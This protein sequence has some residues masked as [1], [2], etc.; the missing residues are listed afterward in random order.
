MLL[1]CSPPSEL[2]MG[3]DKDHKLWILNTQPG[4]TKAKSAPVTQGLKYTHTKR[5]HHRSVWIFWRWFILMQKFDKMFPESYACL[6]CT[7]EVRCQSEVILGVGGC[8]M[9]RTGIA[10]LTNTVDIFFREE[11]MMGY[12]LELCI[13]TLFPALF[14]VHSLSS[15]LSHYS[16]HGSRS[17][18]LSIL[19]CSLSSSPAFLLLP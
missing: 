14:S 2:S 18:S 12:L 7:T 4:R 8:E 3:P 5:L 10:Y 15:F 17:L 13:H 9:C 16:P 11:C 1:A 6:I 19:P